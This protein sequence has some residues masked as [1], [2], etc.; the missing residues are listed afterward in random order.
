MARPPFDCCSVNICRPSLY[1]CCSARR[2]DR[3]VSRRASSCSPSETESALHDGLCAQCN[4]FDKGVR[5]IMKPF[6]PG[7]LGAKVRDVLDEGA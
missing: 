3:G 2:N 7:E 6:A 4:R 5:L 1:R